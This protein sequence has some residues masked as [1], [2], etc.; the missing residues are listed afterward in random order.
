MH[1]IQSSFTSGLVLSLSWSLFF[2]LYIKYWVFSSTVVA[3]NSNYMFSHIFNWN[4]FPEP[5]CLPEALTW[6]T[7]RHLTLTIS[8]R[9]PLTISLE[10][11]PR[12]VSP[13]SE[14][15]VL[16]IPF[17]QG[18]NFDDILDSSLTSQIRPGSNRRRLCNQLVL[19]TQEKYWRITLRKN[20][21][22]KSIVIIAK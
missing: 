11:V 12:K 3:L 16:I 2:S 15:D 13:F 6:V 20:W 1:S 17:A 21:N 14:N 22:C 18:K 8:R 5:E 19:Y 4:L 9:E 10:P 7:N